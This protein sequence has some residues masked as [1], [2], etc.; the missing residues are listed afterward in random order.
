ML[1]QTIEKLNQTFKLSTHLALLAVEAG[2]VVTADVTRRV[3]LLEGFLPPANL[4]GVGL[5]VKYVICQR[6]KNSIYSL[7]HDLIMR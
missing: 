2:L 7:F 6:G 4:E 5:R 3:L 1:R